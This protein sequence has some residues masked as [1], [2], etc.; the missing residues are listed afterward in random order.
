MFNRHT[1]VFPARQGAVRNE[2][3]GRD[4]FCDAVICD[5]FRLHR[6]LCGFVDF[7]SERA[8]APGPRV[9]QLEQEERMEPFCGEVACEVCV[10]VPGVVHGDVCILILI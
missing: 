5:G 6:V 2:Y 10:P 1:I 3:Q 4:D 8:L 9:S 7:F